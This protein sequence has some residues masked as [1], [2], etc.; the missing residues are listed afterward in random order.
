MLF[1]GNVYTEN[2]FCLLTQFCAVSDL[3][4]FL[5]VPACYII[6]EKGYSCPGEQHSNCIL[7]GY[8]LYCNSQ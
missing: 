8:E 5:E 3:R 7:L 2:Q 6:A 4:H 1:N